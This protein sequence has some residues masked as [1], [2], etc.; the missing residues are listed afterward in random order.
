MKTK[1]ARK[2]R[3]TGQ[4]LNSAGDGH[5]EDDTISKRVKKV[6]RMRHSGELKAT[7]KAYAYFKGRDTTSTDVLR[8]RH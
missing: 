7:G 6:D 1:N 8:F 5:L 4:I 3:T 2:R